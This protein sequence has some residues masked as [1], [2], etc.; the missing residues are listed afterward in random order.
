MPNKK[1]KEQRVTLRVPPDLYAELEALTGGTPRKMTAV[2]L[3]RLRSQSGTT[4]S[5][6]EGLMPILA[7]LSTMLD[8]I[9]DAD[10]YSS[11]HMDTARLLYGSL[12]EKA[13]KLLGDGQ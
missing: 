2:I 4:V 7:M 8:Q 3:A 13:F 5:I 6:A 12:L 1:T 10:T 11:E 9:R